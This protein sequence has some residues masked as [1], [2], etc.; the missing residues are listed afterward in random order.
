MEPDNA[1]YDAAS[2]LLAAAQRMDRAVQR[3]GVEPA[4]RHGV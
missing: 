3:D 4:I 1:L 2:D